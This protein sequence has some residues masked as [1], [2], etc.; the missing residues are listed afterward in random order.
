MMARHRGPSTSRR[1]GFCASV[2]SLCVLA[3]VVLS[4]EVNEEEG[5]HPDPNDEHHPGMIYIGRLEGEK[6]EDRRRVGFEHD[7]G[8]WT[9]LPPNLTDLAIGTKRC[10]F[11]GGG[12]GEPQ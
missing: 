4:N 11:R 3:A 5:P 8:E 12:V 1:R 9:Y 10:T 2:W 7:N 6:D